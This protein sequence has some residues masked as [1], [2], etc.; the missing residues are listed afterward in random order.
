MAMGLLSVAPGPI[1][2]VAA[3]RYFVQGIV[4]TRLKN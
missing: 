1:L 3:Q 4:T 2:Y